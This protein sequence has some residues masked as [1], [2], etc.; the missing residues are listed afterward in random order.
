MFAQGL[1]QR[2]ALFGRQATRA[3][4]ARV[5]GLRPGG[6][7]GPGPLAGPSFVAPAGPLGFELLTQFLA[8]LLA[9]G[10]VMVGGATVPT[11]RRRGRQQQRA[12]SDPPEALDTVHVE[13]PDPSILGRPA[14][15][16]R[17]GRGKRRNPG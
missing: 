4:V 10:P 13:P 14:A 1:A 9:L 17:A 5:P 2:P 11:E 3:G 16:A 6:A 12:R 7:S 15:P 8:P